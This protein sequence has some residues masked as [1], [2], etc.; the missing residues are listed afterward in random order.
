MELRRI[1]RNMMPQT[2]L[3]SGL[4]AALKELCTLTAND[5]LKVY[6]KFMNLRRDLSTQVQLIIYRIVQELLANVVK[7]AA[8]T[9]AFVQ[10]SQD[11]NMF[12]LTVEDNGSGYTQKDRHIRT[13]LGLENI[14]SRIDFL[15][16]KMEVAGG[17]GKG[18]IVNIELNTD[19]KK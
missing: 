19:E 12:Y 10:C 6:S 16:G 14:K 5:R 7:H 2:L 3:N 9:E 8:A 17:S 4:E 1:A 18:T 13:G 15:K 11:E